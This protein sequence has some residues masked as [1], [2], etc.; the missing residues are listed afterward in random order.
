M[1]NGMWLHHPQGLHLL[2]MLVLPQ[3]PTEWR[4]FP[5]E[6]LFSPRKQIIFLRRE[7]FYKASRILQKIL[8]FERTVKQQI[9]LVSVMWGQHPC[10]ADCQTCGITVDSFSL[11]ASILLLVLWPTAG[12]PDLSRVGAWSAAQSA[13]W[14]AWGSLL[15]AVGIHCY[16]VLCSPG[17][18]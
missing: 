13:C 2:M 12:E 15:K 17:M 4:I 3:R 14:S 6:I 9:Y 11:W 16:A 8:N 5:L 1:S 18:C 7:A 10:P